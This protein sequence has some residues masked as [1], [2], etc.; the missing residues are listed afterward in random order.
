MTTSTTG[1]AVVR[2]RVLQLLPSGLIVELPDGRSG[3]VRPRELSW[4]AD[5]RQEWRQ[6]FQVGQEVLARVLPA[7]TSAQPELSLR[8]AERDP[9]LDIDDR[10]APNQVVAG[11]VT[12][13]ESFGA[14]IDLEPGITGLLHYSRLPDGLTVPPQDVFWPGDHVRVVIESIDP[15]RRRIGVSADR[16]PRWIAAGAGA[17]AVPGDE[18]W[19]GSDALRR[20]AQ[21]ERFTNMSR[22]LSVVLMDDDPDPRRA[23]AHWLERAG[24]LVQ[25][26]ESVADADA[27]VRDLAPDVL[28][29][30]VG[31][32]A[33]AGLELVRRLRAEVPGLNVV[34]LTDIMTADHDVVELE[35]LQLAGVRIVIKPIWPEDLIDALLGDA[36]A[37]DLASVAGVPAV[38]GRAGESAVGGLGT[39]VD[40]V[41][42]RLARLQKVTTA[43]KIVLFRVDS[44]RRQVEVEA[45]VGR[46]PL[47]GRARADL[48][49]SPVRDAAEDGQVVRIRDGERAGD[50]ARHLLPLLPFEA[51]LGVPVPADVTQRYALFLFFDDPRRLTGLAEEHARAAAVA[52]GALVERAQ[53]AA[54]ASDLQRLAFLGQVNQTLVHELNHG[55]MPLAF[56]LDD[57]KVLLKCLDGHLAED[58]AAGADDIA[59]LQAKLDDIGGALYNLTETARLFGLLAM[60]RE[61]QLIRLD[62][63]IRDVARMVG[64]VARR[65]R[66][67]VSFQP[68]PDLT[69]TRL[70]ASHLQQVLIN[71]VIN[72]VQQIALFRRSAGGRVELY[73]D[74]NRRDGTT[75][76]RIRVLDDGPGIHRRLWERIFD[77]GF[78]S[79][80]GQDNEGS[81]LGLYVSRVLAERLGGRVYVAESHVLSGSEFV[82]EMPL[83]L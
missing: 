73:I 3:R 57:A 37:L 8:L 50:W 24:H 29:A 52:L 7:G 32:P 79:R 35:A 1:T 77:M 70:H 76:L 12:G 44:V 61:D 67:T 22:P 38:D 62:D 51:C 56:S 46:E 59:A 78:T 53:F 68:P 5:V 30:D 14:F 45:E 15:R 82:V 13:I 49:H 48:I 71:V 31:R 47:R 65:N 33:R 2:A 26:A 19:A 18:E 42:H 4:N 81:G 63:A 74:R 25:V 27:L 21:L 11:V 39:D 34:V 75:C 64:A 69:F 41:P 58:P 72:A 54:L 23:V 60:K 17:P 9:W 40:S 80:R 6:H 20:D 36:P 83:N 55:L 28:L 16:L 10:Y 43:H 66:V